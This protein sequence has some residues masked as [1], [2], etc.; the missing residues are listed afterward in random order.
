M[1]QLTTQDIGSVASK[2]LDQALRGGAVYIPGMLNRLLWLLGSLTPPAV[3]AKLI[4]KRWRRAA[5]A[6][7]ETLQR[8]LEIL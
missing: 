8:Q 6:S 1:G 7:H 5:P 4:G 2:T 3:V